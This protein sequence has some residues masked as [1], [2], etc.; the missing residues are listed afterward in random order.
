MI[1]VLFLN[2]FEIFLNK[3]ELNSFQIIVLLILKSVSI[4]SVLSVLLLGIEFD[5]VL[6][7]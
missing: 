1:L 5:R 3:Y 4:L 7:I 2:P 6:R